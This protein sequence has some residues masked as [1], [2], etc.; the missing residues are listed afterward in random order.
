MHDGVTV[1]RKHKWPTASF[2][3]KVLWNIVRTVY[4]KNNAFAKKCT[5]SARYSYV[6]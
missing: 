5:L 4:Y 3:V 1:I 2:V 6:A